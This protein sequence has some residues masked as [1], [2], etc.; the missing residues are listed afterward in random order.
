MDYT[1]HQA[2]LSFIISQS[3]LKLMSFESVMPHN[4]LILCHQLFLLP[5]ILPSIRVFFSDL[6]LCSRRPKYC[7]FSFTISPS[8]EYSE[9]ISFT[10]D[11]FDLLALQGTQARIWNGETFRSPGDLLGPG[12]E[13]LLHCR[14]I[15]YCLRHQGSLFYPLKSPKFPYY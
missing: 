3:V 8:S 9:L 4:H 10:I 14:Q 7:S 1:E 15:L 6:A 11:W 12:I 2:T 13:C 5:S